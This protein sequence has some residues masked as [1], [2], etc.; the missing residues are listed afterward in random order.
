MASPIDTFKNN[1]F[2]QLKTYGDAVQGAFEQRI[3]KHFNRF[4]HYHPPLLARPLLALKQDLYRSSSTSRTSSERES[5]AETTFVS[6]EH[7]ILASSSPL[8][9][10]DIETP[11]PLKALLDKFKNAFSSS[12]PRGTS[13]DCPPP[14]P[15]PPDQI[16]SSTKEH[17]HSSISTLPAK[18][19]RQ[20]QFRHKSVSFAEHNPME[21]H[22]STTMD[23]CD[24]RILPSNP[25]RHVLSTTDEDATDIHQ[26]LRRV[27]QPRRISIGHGNDLLYQDLAAE[28]VAYVLKH[29]LRAVEE[30][31]DQF[32]DL[33]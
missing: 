3:G 12:N 26:H 18:A 27:I 10:I 22:V 21:E 8:E 32:I 25:D 15:A 28:I 9:I 14:P 16:E 29:A 11:D 19:R 1:L 17:H 7:S 24:E 31:E 33:K 20:K 23:S 6:Y 13:E 4:I 2:G 5:T 30:E